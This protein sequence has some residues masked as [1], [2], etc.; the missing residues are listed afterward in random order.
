MALGYS[1]TVYSPASTAL[2]EIIRVLWPR[3]SCCRAY[4]VS[5]NLESLCILTCVCCQL[6]ILKAIGGAWDSKQPSAELVQCIEL[7]QHCCDDMEALL[8]EVRHHARI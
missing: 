3:I 2:C 5:D 1:E 8:E 6:Q 4:Q 7:L